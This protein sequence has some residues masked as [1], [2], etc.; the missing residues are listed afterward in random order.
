MIFARLLSVLA[1]LGGGELRR[2]DDGIPGRESGHRRPDRGHD[3]GL[4]E[5]RERPCNRPD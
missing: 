2:F 1:G 3:R 5:R 4:N